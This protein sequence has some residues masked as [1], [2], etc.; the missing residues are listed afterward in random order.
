MSRSQAEEKAMDLLRQVGKKYEHSF[1]DGKNK[2]EV[3]L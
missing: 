3:Q 2:I 1:A